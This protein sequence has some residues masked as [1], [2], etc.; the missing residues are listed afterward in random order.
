M[1]KVWSVLGLIVFL[2][3]PAT[4][5]NKEQSRIENAGKATKEITD[6][7]DDIPQSVIDKTDSLLCCLPCSNLQSASAAAT[8]GSYD[9]PG[10]E[11]FSRQLG[12]TYYDGARRRELWVATGRPADRLRLAFDELTGCL[13]HPKQQ[14]KAWRRCISGGWTG[15]EECVG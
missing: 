4:A 6:V 2:A 14:G 11:E 15:R 5:Q 1:K 8:A 13:E 12:A 10:W 9:L 3:Q 7:P